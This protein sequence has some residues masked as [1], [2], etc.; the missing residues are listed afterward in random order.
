MVPCWS[1]ALSCPG[2]NSAATPKSASFASPRELS[3]T[4]SGFRSRC[5]A[6]SGGACS[7][8]RPCRTCRSTEAS[9]GSGAGARR[10]ACPASIA[11]IKMCVCPSPS[12]WYASRTATSPAGCGSSGS[13]RC[14]KRS[15][16]RAAR[17]LSSA[18]PTMIFSAA[19]ATPSSSKCTSTAADAPRPTK[20][21]DLRRF[22]RWT[23]D[24]V[25]LHTLA[26]GDTRSASSVVAA[27]CASAPCTAR[28]LL[29][30]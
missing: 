10:P 2:G 29:P 24:E 19:M 8:A 9:T 1:I 23:F 3:S 15:S 7:A 17:I 30:R 11:S 4:F 14:A 25:R 13:C 28:G 20:T 18:P 5:S 27:A 12:L 21:D 26:I 22:M 6:R 16:V